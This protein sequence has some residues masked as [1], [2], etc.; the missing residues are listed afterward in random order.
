MN[1]LTP[2]KIM[3]WKYSLSQT[4]KLEPKILVTSGCSF[5]A[6]TQQLRSAASWPGYMRDR[7]RFDHAIDLSYPAAGNEYIADSILGYFKDKTDYSNHFVVVMWS[8]LDR[9]EIQTSNSKDPKI[10]NISYIRNHSDRML[11]KEE[12]AITT[13]LSYDKI[14]ETYNFLITHQIPFAFTFYCNVLFP[15]YIPKRDRTHEI[16][17]YLNKD[18]I[19][20]LQSIINVPLDQTNFLYEYAFFNDHTNGEDGFHP[21]GNGNLAWVDSI[22][23]PDLCKLGLLSAVDQ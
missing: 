19:A 3:Q 5:T 18:S 4:H 1:L 21:T 22:L 14:V 11:S 20:H 10:G 8:G 9:R 12:R 16:D 6:S 23:L 17:G 7:C 15:P 13:Q 2:P